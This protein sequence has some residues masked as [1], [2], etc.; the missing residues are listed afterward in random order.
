[1]DL[2]ELA[3]KIKDRLDI[4]DIISEYLSDLKKRGKNYVRICPFHS[5]K[6]P[7]FTVSREK[8]MYY[9]FGCGEGGDIIKFVE[10]YENITFFEALKKLAAKANI[11][12]DS[13]NIKN[14]SQ[15]EKEKIIIKEMNLQAS[16]VY[17]KL[18]KSS[19]GKKAMDY[20]TDR[21]LKPETIASFNLG[22][23]PYGENI[24][25]KE[26][27][28]KYSK[29]LLIKSGLVS[30]KEGN[31]TDY[32]H[33]RII[34]PIKSYSQD[35]IGFGARAL[36]PEAQPKYL[37]SM[38]TPVFSKRKAL[39]GISKAINGI[40]KFKKAVLVEGYFDV[41]TLHQYMIDIAVSPL[42]T[43]FTP[44]QAI[45]LKNYIEEAIIIFDSDRAGINA[46]IKT[47]NLLTEHGIYPRIV[48]FPENIDPDEFLIKYGIEEFINLLN[49]APDVIEFKIKL[50][51]DKNVNL[52]NAEEKLKVVG[53][54][55]DTI[56]RQSNNIIRD[57][58]IKKTSQALDINETIIKNYLSKNMKQVK[59]QISS[60]VQK[61]EF[62]EIELNFIQIILNNP[63][64]VNNLEDFKSEYLTS[65]FTKRIY[66][67][68]KE[69]LDKEE[70]LIEN[71]FN[72]FPEYKNTVLKL[73]MNDENNDIF[74]ITNLNK[75]AKLIKKNYLETEWKKLKSKINNLN[76][77]EMEYFNKLT[78]EL[79]NIKI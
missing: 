52:S 38:E 64:L 34:I 43:S 3:R 13:E 74:N 56:K 41:I 9:C 66:E 23:A 17:Q 28:K 5:E 53:Y 40:R 6:T 16:L 37:N 67:H 49:D 22:Y 35:I 57:E 63:E 12:I 29:E 27:S 33:D 30:V 26:L 25:V 62:P 65:Q 7:S 20:L 4:V 72:I 46:A 47:A 45:F 58:W 60:S 14:L 68:I 77:Q 31:L 2:S 48:I 51:K 79:K 70:N 59:E 78:I 10:K 76:E 32:F 75:T 11:V 55:C 54:I 69:N 1:M 39:F 15:S 42:G 8:Q 18:L 24:I 50:I 73:I 71:L 44:E 19:A 21:G 36:S 61:N